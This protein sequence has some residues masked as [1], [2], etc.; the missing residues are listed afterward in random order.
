MAKLQALTSEEARRKADERFRRVKQRESDAQTAYD[1]LAKIQKAEAAK[2]ERLRS[3]RLAK[4][5]ADAETAR[6]E[7]EDKARAADEARQRKALRT[8]STISKEPA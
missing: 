5:A 7:A 6:R 4:E 3:L 1:E 2:T 8:P